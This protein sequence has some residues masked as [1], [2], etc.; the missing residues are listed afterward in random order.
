MSL[1]DDDDDERRSVSD[2]VIFRKKKKRQFCSVDK[3]ML[4]LKETK[5]KGI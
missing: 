1:Y 5:L 2:Y 3:L 4:K